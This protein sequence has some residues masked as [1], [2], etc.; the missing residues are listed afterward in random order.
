MRARSTWL[1]LGMMSMFAGCASAPARDEL[2]GPATDAVEIPPESAPSVAA[3]DPFAG[4][5]PPLMASAL[6][7]QSEGGLLGLDVQGWL[8]NYALSHTD[9]ARPWLLLARDSM[10]REWGGWAERQYAS[11]IESDPR[12]VEVPFVLADLI[13]VA[14][15]FIGIDRDEA[16]LLVVTHWG[17]DALPAI[18]RALVAAEARGDDAAVDGLK[19]LSEAIIGE[20]A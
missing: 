15:E 19:S 6:A 11:A 4:A 2:A 18:D 12:V 1:V 17:S 5:M 10:A 13:I 16:T 14:S 7:T 20:S 3:Y 9:D 8:F